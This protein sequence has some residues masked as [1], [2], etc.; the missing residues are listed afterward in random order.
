MRRCGPWTRIG[1]ASAC[2]AAVAVGAAGSLWSCAPPKVQTTFLTN[3]DLVD[4]TER[5]AT[6][7]AASPAM[8]ARTRESPRWIISIDRVDNRTNQ[9]IPEDQKWIFVGR[10]RALLAATRLTDQKNLAWIVP[11]EKWAI[12]QQ[13]LRMYGEPPEL[14]MRPTHLMTAQ[15]SA[16]T[17]T[18]GAGRSDAYFCSFQLVDLA[19]G[20]LV[21]EDGW[22]VK[23]EVVGKTYD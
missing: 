20:G 15:F 3:V 4:M 16:L 6:S 10:L 18:S 13:E 17:T 22:E 2:A 21:W 7:F 11:Q 12:I 5:M 1:R 8:Q 14:R 9:I 19:T 23:R